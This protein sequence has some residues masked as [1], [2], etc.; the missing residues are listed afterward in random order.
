MAVQDKVQTKVHPLNQELTQAVNASMSP[1][2]AT[3]IIFTEQDRPAKE[4][5]VLSYNMQL[6]PIW[7]KYD[8]ADRFVHERLADFA[9]SYFQDYDVLCLQE[10]WALA[11]SDIKEV[12]ISYGQKAGLL[13]H[14]SQPSHH[15]LLHSKFSAD[16]G[17][18]I[19]SR[20][21]IVASN[22]HRFSFG[23]GRDSEAKRGVLHAQIRL[24][25]NSLINVFSAHL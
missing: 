11:T 18:L 24:T 17:L 2:E 6:L 25:D 14:A 8:A 21:P 3:K 13:Y 5:R 16:S 4:V 7:P 15:T 20:F 23:V 12:I 1:S 19:L 10:V 22:F 9:V